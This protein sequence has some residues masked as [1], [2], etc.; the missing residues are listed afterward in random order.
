MFNISSFFSKFVSL[1]K[2][3]NTKIY[4][5]LDMIKKITGLELAKEMLE[6]K[7][8]QLKINCNPVFKNEIFM[9]KSEI[10]NCL[11]SKNIFL[12]IF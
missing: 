10:E 1:E 6:V 8:S 9:H 3:N 7:E 2:D 5:I 12:S 4:V 11:K